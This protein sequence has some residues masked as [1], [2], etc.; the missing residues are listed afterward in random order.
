MEDLLI[1]NKS[2]SLFLLWNILFCQKILQK[3][4]FIINIFVLY[5]VNKFFDMFLSLYI[6]CSFCY[7]SL[8]IQHRALCL[9]R[10]K[11]E[12]L[13]SKFSLIRS[14]IE[15]IPS[16][17]CSIDWMEFLETPLSGSEQSL[18]NR[19]KNFNFKIDL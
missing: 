6:F 9:N 10:A 2:L 14:Q 1:T 16:V 5:M 12:W 4:L 11:N 8:K 15:K 19:S 7:S 3:L 13:I 17:H 18:K